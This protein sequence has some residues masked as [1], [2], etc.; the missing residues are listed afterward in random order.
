VDMS[1]N[2]LSANLPDD[3]FTS[4]ESLKELYISDCGLN[5]LP[6]R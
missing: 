4:L 5:T 3:M 6:K 1:E 2:K